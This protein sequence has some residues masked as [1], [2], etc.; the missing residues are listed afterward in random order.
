MRPD[1]PCAVSD[2]DWYTLIT[3]AEKV[4]C[5]V[6]NGR[7]S[8]PLTRPEVVISVYEDCLRDMIGEMTDNAIRAVIDKLTELNNG[9]PIV[10]GVTVDGVPIP[11][12]VP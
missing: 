6:T 5:A 10:S 8:N 3:S 11:G 7:I 9:V 4:Y 2:P 1:K 12:G